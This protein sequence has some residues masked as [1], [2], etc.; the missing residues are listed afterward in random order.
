MSDNFWSNCKHFT[1][2]L[3]IDNIWQIY[4]Q[5]INLQHG[6]SFVPLPCNILIETVSVKIYL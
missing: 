5:M 6:E 3:F 1:L 2:I 4:H